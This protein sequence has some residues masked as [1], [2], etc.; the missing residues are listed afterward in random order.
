MRIVLSTPTHGSLLTGNRCTAN[1]WAGVFSDLGH[2]VEI[3]D[4]NSHDQLPASDLLVTLHG[5]YSEPIIKES[6]KDSPDKPIILAMT[7]TDIYPEPNE[8]VQKSLHLADIIIV[9]QSKAIE[10]IPSQF[11]AKTEVIFQSAKKFSGKTNPDPNYF[12][13]CVVGHLRDVKD[14]MR[15]AVA[16]RNLPESSQIRIFHA[17]GILDPKYLEIVRA[18]E[19]KNPRYHW[20]GNLSEMEV[21][22]L[23]AESKLMT[24]TSLSEGGARV[25]GESV[26]N[27]TPIISSAIDGVIGLIGEDYPGYFPT[28]DTLALTELLCETERDPQFFKSLQLHTETIAPRFHPDREKEAWKLLLQRFE[29]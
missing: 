25:V 13:V 27:L 22:Q 4:I 3:Y 6:R 23:I 18:E 17:G 8:T 5:E 16:A 20:I 19:S 7:G 21:S 10:R 9:L 28:G 11:R 29:T 2:K 1:Q 26:L 15:T 14:P 12:D 24:I